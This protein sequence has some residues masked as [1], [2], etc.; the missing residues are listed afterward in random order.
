MTGI[1]EPTPKIRKQFKEGM[2]GHIGDNNIRAAVSRNS[3]NRSLPN[4]HSVLDAIL[5]DILPCIL[6][7]S[8]FNVDSQDGRC[9]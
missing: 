2:P 1:G 8:R 4:R 9:P 3:V 6:D 7:R 5:C